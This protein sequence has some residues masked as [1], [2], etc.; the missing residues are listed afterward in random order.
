MAA[1]TPIDTPRR[2]GIEHAH[3]IDQLL[4]FLDNSHRPRQTP[5][6]SGGSME[7]HPQRHRYRRGGCSC[8]SPRTVDQILVPPV[9]SPGGSGVS[10]RLWGHGE[11]HP[12]GSRVTARMVAG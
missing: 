5:L 1:R 9:K 3:A 2:D 11:T 4:L 10:A 7:A 12:S 8:P 6:T